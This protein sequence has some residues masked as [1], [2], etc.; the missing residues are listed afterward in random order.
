[1]NVDLKRRNAGR[2]GDLARRVELAGAF[3]ALGDPTRLAILQAISLQDLSPDALAA[4]L[5]ISGN[6]LA[7]HLKVLQQAGLIHRIHSQHDRRR[8]YVQSR[9]GD[10]PW[11]ADLLGER[12]E[13]KAP[14]VVFVCTHNS[15]RSVLAEALWRE[16]SA[17]PTSSAGTAPAASVHPR[18]RR[19]ARSLGLPM[20]NRHP[21]HLDEVLRSGDVVVSVCDAVNEELPS[22]PNRR[23]HWSI[24]DPSAI[25]TDRAFRE[26]TNHLRLRV[27]R[28]A[29][30]VKGPTSD[31][32]EMKES[33]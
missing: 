29:A 17:V 30:Y 10:W 32:I 4:E 5:G 1:M 11:L 12:T 18:A 23:L 28:L 13:L 3:A 14:R 26:A 21:A 22:M 16:V 8:S 19:V 15:A 31:H 25:D 7:H 9:V 6:L 24:A 20:R 2:A 27:E 33:R